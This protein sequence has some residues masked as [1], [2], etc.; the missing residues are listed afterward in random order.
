M[1]YTYLLHIILHRTNERVN[2]SSSERIW[3]ELT[4]KIRSL[5]LN[6]V[7]HVAHNYILSVYYYYPLK[8]LLVLSSSAIYVNLLKYSIFFFQSDW[9]TLSTSTQWTWILFLN[10]VFLDVFLL[11]RTLTQTGKVLS[12]SKINCGSCRPFTCFTDQ[13]VCV[14]TLC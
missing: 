12:Y 8:L 1:N 14:Y 6:I 13:F 5:K 3:N 11:K 9:V 7:I 4:K 2:K 10:K